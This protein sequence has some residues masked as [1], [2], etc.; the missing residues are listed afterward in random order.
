MSQ[1]QTT[2]YIGIQLLSPITN[3]KRYDTVFNEILQYLQM[4]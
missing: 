2:I 1:H 3:Q 4:N